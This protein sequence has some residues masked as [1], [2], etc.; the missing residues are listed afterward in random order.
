MKTGTNDWRDN[1]CL[2][3]EMLKIVSVVSFYNLICSS[4][5]VKIVRD[6]F[7]GIN[8]VTQVCVKRGKIQNIKNTEK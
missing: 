6:L 8:R 5:S 2:W 7:V 1:S 3:V 4:I